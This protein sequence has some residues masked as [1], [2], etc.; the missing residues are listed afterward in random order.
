MPNHTPS[1]TTIN[2]RSRLVH[3]LQRNDPKHLAL[4]TE[5]DQLLICRIL[6]ASQPAY[7]LLQVGRLHLRLIDPRP[8]NRTV[9]HIQTLSLAV[10]NLRRLL[11]LSLVPTTLLSVNLLILIYSIDLPPLHYQAP[12]LLRHQSHPKSLLV[13]RQ[14]DRGS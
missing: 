12:S 14:R 7:H 1:T 11:Y 9:V 8:N 13:S 3:V 10:I 5:Q 4:E 6:F 2:P